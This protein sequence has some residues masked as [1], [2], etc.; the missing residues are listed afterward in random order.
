MTEFL[1][2]SDQ[3]FYFRVHPCKKFVLVVLKWK[4]DS[5]GERGFCLRY[6]NHLEGTKLVH[7]VPAKYEVLSDKYRNIL[8]FS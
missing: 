3:N 6:R 5:F 1:V 8:L 2:E 7:T 4:I